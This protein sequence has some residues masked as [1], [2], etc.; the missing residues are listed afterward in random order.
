MLSTRAPAWCLWTLFCPATN[1]RLRLSALPITECT[2]LAQ[3]TSLS[4]WEN[5]PVLELMLWLALE[6][7][8]PFATKEYLCCKCWDIFTCSKYILSSVVHY[9]AESFLENNYIAP[10]L[11]TFVAVPSNRKQQPLLSASCLQ[12]PFQYVHA[13]H[14]PP[15]VQHVLQR[16]PELEPIL[17]KH[18]HACLVPLQR[19]HH[20]PPNPHPRDSPLLQ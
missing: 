17:L 19:G 3:R 11:S 14:R 2:L 18:A 5:Q 13:V 9:A 1:G 10:A 7:I 12:R 6:K 15:Y 20:H 16:L 4:L 8:R